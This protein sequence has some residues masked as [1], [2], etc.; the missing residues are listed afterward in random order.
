MLL[1]E[2][3]EEG[4]GLGVGDGV[5]AVGV[6]LLPAAL[7]D[8]AVLELQALLHKIISPLLFHLIIVQ[9]ESIT[10]T[11]TSPPSCTAA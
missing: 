8:E 1:E 10:R 4:F 11:C 9:I 2:G 6:G 3:V 5:V 7:H